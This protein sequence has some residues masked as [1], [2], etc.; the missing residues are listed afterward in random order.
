MPTLSSPIVAATIPSM[1]AHT[2]A[3]PAAAPAFDNANLV[4]NVD[5]FLL[6]FACLFFL[7]ALPRAVI[8]FSHSS[9]WFDGQLLHYVKVRPRRVARPDAKLVSPESVYLAPPSAGSADW[10]NDSEKYMDGGG[11]S[12][13][14]H[15]VLN[16]SGSSSSQA[17]LLRSYSTSSGRARRAAL[18]L[19]VHMPN[20]TTMLPQLSWITRISLRPGLTVGGATILV[21][22]FAVMIYAGF[23]K[24]NVFTDPLRTGYVATSQ[25]PVVILLATKVNVLGM[26]LG[27]AYT[28]VRVFLTF[29]MAS[30]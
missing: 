23:Y 25:I 17:H 28:R 11:Y 24:S 5:I 21:A 4:F 8:R 19:Q 29:F 22:Y 30:P 9:E 14:S 27:A 15:A 7:L 26:L 3:T 13:A 12:A 10:L 2:S 18:D 6:A 16:R 1:T 20:W